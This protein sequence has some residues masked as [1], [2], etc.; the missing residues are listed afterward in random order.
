[1]SESVAVSDAVQVAAAEFNVAPSSTKGQRW[2]R[3]Y[4]L[5]AVGAVII[6]A[7]I[8][9][10]VAAPWLAP[11]KPDLVDVTQRLLPPSSLHWRWAATCS[12][13]CST[14]PGSRCS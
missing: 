1:M 13:A 6:V 7:W 3:R 5:A 10:A 11:Y 9:V 8:V 12:R 14:A 2:R 4:G